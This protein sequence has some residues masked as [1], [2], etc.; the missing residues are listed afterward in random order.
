MLGKITANSHSES[1]VADLIIG[2]DN[3]KPNLCSN[4]KVFYVMI[5]NH[6]ISEDELKYIYAYSTPKSTNGLVLYLPLNEGAGEIAHDKSGYKNNASIVGA[7]WSTFSPTPTPTGFDTNLFLF[8]LG[9]FAVA[10]SIT[11]VC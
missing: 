6:A 4:I 9:V 5:F 2:A 1:G 7:S 8:V 3:D 10:V 11:I